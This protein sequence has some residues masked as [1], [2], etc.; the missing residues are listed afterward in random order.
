VDLGAHPGPV[1]LRAQTL[2]E[3]RG[4]LRRRGRVTSSLLA[5]ELDAAASLPADERPTLD[6]WLERL[7]DP[8]APWSSEPWTVLVAGGDLAVLEGGAIEVDGPLVL[9]AGGRIRVDGNSVVTQG[10][11]WKTP[12]GGGVA[13]GRIETLPLALAPP[14]LDP[15][16]APLSACAVSRPL[17]WTPRSDRWRTTL[18]G[19]VGAGRIDVAFLQASAAGAPERVFADPAALVAGDV[20]VLVRLEIGPGRG[21]AW[22]PPILERLELEPL[23]PP[24]VRPERDPH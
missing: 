16:R 10:D 13:H 21:A 18:I 7:L 5:E 8:G 14:E 23:P 9:V 20:R 19:S 11:L 15:L 6:A 3:V 17:K 2:L 12:A 24:M 4:R 1:V 22:D